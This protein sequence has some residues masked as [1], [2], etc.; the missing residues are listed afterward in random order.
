MSVPLPE[1]R[2]VD[3]SDEQR[4]LLLLRYVVFVEEQK[5]PLE[6]EMDGMDSTSTH[7]LATLNAN[8]PVGTGRLL[9]SGQIGRM[10]VLKSFRNDGF[11]SLILQTIVRH[12]KSQGYD[13]LFLHAQNHAIPFY[14]KHGFVVQGDEFL[15]AGIAHHEMVLPR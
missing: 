14:E 10:A 15:D 12:G 7:F 11:G 5:V 13:R 4:T 3:W 2:C 9:P 8:L 6:E 1:V